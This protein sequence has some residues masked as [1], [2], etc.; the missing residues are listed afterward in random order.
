MKLTADWLAENHVQTV[1]GLL[2]RGGHQALLVGGCV[3]NAA[4]AQPVSDIDIATDATPE[5]VLEL[6]AA[7]G[8]KAVPTGI[9]HGTVT[10]V[11]DHHPHEVTTFRRDVETFGRHAVVAFSTDVLEDAQRRDFTMNAL[12]ATADGTVL[13]PLGEGLADLAAGRLRFVGPPSARIQEDY[14]RILRFFRFTAWFGAPDLGMDAEGLAACAEFASGIETLS[15]ERIGHEMRKLL[16]APNPAP[17]VAAMAA[18]GVLAQVLPGADPRALAPLIHLEKTLSPEADTPCPL[19]RLAALGGKDRAERLRLSKAEMRR[20]ETLKTA[21]ADP[22]PEDALGYRYGAAVARDALLL[23]AA[24]M[25]QGLDRTG[26]NKVAFGAAQTF[27]LRAADLMPA[28]SGPALGAALA[29]AEA[30]W[31]ASGFT[32]PR[33]ALLRGDG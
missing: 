10:L 14:L 11:V 1:L 16:A 8:I 17:A 27:P 30:R 26:F 20:L 28:L 22:A 29:K 31:V 15:R 13:D 33:E 7:A 18:S 21:V 5:R 4:L 2:A 32:L 9:D 25:G 23:R 6:A 3:R 24:L 19:R 12:Y